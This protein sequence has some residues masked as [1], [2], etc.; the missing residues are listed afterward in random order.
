MKLPGGGTAGI[1]AGT[2]AETE[3]GTETGTGTQSHPSHL[4]HFIP[5]LPPP[6]LSYEVVCLA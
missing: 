3:A 2:E 6:F 5:F 4:F 1:E